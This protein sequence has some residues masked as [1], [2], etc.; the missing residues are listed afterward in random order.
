[1]GKITSVRSLAT[2]VAAIVVAAVLVPV[3]GPTLD[4][5]SAAPAAAHVFVPTAVSLP[6]RDAVESPTF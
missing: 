1:M 4:A 5:G 3:S 6:D 2:L